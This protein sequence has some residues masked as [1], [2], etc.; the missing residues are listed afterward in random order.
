MLIA[1]NYFLSSGFKMTFIS[2]K[3]ETSM[4]RTEPQKLKQVFEDSSIP[5]EDKSKSKRINCFYA[6]ISDSSSSRYTDEE[7]LAL[8]EKLTS[9]RSDLN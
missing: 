3:M 4:G 8:K 7:I 2:Q 9:A 1:H 5:K 6:I